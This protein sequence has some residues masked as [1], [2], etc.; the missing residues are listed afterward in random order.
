VFA[1]FA[2]VGRGWVTLGSMDR[3]KLQIGEGDGMG[4]G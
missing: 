1:G 2:V 4:L 3:G